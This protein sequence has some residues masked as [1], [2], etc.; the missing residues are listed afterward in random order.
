M[1]GRIVNLDVARGIAILG[2]LATNIWIFSHP[3]GMLGYLTHPT[4]VGAPVWQQQL[5]AFIQ[6]LA[7][8]KFL[9]VLTLMFGIGLAIQADSAQRKGQRWPGPY[10]WR[11]ALLLLDGLLHY[12][13]VVEFDVLM[14]YAVTGG[15]VAYIIASS[16]RTQRW[17][18]IGA[19]AVHVALMSLLTYSLLAF[20]ANDASAVDPNLYRDGSWWDLV[21]MRVQYVA[22]FRAEPILIAAMSV[23]MFL[24]GH[25]LLR[26]G[27]FRPDGATL[28]RRMMIAG[29]IA[30]PIDLGLP[31]LNPDLML[32]AR[33]LTA[34]IVALGLLALIAGRPEPGWAGRR[35][36]E[37]GR[38]ALSGY[39]AQNILASALF[40]GWGLDLG[41][42]A[43]QWRLVTTIGGYLLVAAAVLVFAHLWQ[44][45]F[46][47]GPVEW[48]W[49]RC[50]QA[51]SGSP[52]QAADRHPTAV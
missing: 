17:W 26:A 49:V 31:L 32:T 14:G 51:L 39:I 48:L 8:G 4:S 13:L 41:G 50:Y 19:V 40:Y 9:G 20:P 47:R 23:A 46:R 15:I 37:L 36:A 12:L 44:R 11:A 52:R 28:R 22:I 3:E 10:L 25:H 2:T 16:P 21:V 18:L 6:Q 35:C 24:L 45:R 42:V 30:L 43:P 7:N 38:M 33:Y 1:S 29:A 27:L 5:E 34:P